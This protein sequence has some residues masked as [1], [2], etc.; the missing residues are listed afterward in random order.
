M[1]DI[2]SNAMTNSLSFA[3]L[4]IAGATAFFF[5]R[6]RRH[7]RFA[8]ENDYTESLLE[9]HFQVIEVLIRLRGGTVLSAEQRKLD[10]ARLSALIEQ[11]RFFFPNIKA[12][13]GKDKPPAYRGYRNL[14]LDMLVASYN[15]F[16]DPSTTD[17]EERAL[18]L[19]RHFTSI[20][21]EIVRPHS[22]LETIRALTDRY[23]AQQKSFEDFLDTGDPAAIEHIWR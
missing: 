2:S 8:I 12:D 4:I 14:A 18:V 13:F 11:G 6:D 22:R 3:S 23:F 10:L 7:A 16:A 20:V 9:W 19:Q 21:F 1:W 15:L 17:K 5:L